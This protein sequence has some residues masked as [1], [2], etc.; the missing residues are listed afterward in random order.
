[1]NDLANLQHP[2]LAAIAYFDRTIDGYPYVAY[3]A[4][5]GELLSNKIAEWQQA[6]TLTSIEALNIGLQISE[7]LN[8]LYEAGI[9]HYD[10]RPDTIFMGEDNQILLLGLE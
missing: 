5:P 8:V 6:D 2:H 3:E 10:L 1:M 4:V 9:F 7:A